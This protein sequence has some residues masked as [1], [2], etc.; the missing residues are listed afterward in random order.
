M[1]RFNFLKQ[2]NNLTTFRFILFSIITLGIYNVVWFYKRNKLI[3]NTLGV[4]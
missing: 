1:N 3:Q 4:K 2:K